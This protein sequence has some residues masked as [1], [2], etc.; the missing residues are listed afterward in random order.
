MR[1]TMENNQYLK[2]SP[3]QLAKYKRSKLNMIQL[4]LANM[5]S[6]SLWRHKAAIVG[7]LTVILLHKYIKQ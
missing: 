4:P 7:G 5:P 2:N 1:V 6:L 3:R